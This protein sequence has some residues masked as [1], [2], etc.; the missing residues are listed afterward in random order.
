[1]KNIKPNKRNRLHNL[2]ISSRKRIKNCLKNQSVTANTAAITNDIIST[3]Q[4]V[5]ANVPINS[6]VSYELHKIVD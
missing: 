6:Y 1:M 2:T 5:K 3:V 4:A